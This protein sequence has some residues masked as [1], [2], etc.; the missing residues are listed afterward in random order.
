MAASDPAG[1]GQQASAAGGGAGFASAPATSRRQRPTVADVLCPQPYGR[2]PADSEA[3]WARTR[4][5]VSEG[6]CPVP[7]CHG[8][9]LPEPPPDP[10]WWG[11]RCPEHGGFWQTR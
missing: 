10:T 3:F 2:G 1:D 8:R 7:I 6:F 4:A 5:A 9:L 11:G